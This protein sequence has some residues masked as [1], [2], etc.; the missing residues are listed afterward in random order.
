MDGFGQIESLTLLWIWGC[1]QIKGWRIGASRFATAAIAYDGAE[2]VEQRLEAVDHRVIIESLP[3]H[4]TYRSFGRP[5]ATPRPKNPLPQLHSYFQV[6]AVDGHRPT[7]LMKSR[8]P[9]AF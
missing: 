2:V 1:V 6:W 5:G 8:S 4:F 3:A 7:A 9:Y